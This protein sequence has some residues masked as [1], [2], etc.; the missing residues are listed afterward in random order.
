MEIAIIWF[1]TMVGIGNEIDKNSEYIEALEN[2]IVMLKDDINFLED[3]YLVLS[4]AHSDLHA[5][6]EVDKSNVV[7]VL[8]VQKEQ[9]DFL[10]KQVM[11]TSQ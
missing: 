7:E 1:I 2:E 10:I 3:S 8:D 4:A 11:D 5:R 6:H 9:I